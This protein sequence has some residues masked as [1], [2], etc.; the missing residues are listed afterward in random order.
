LLDHVLKELGKPTKMDAITGHPMGGLLGVL[1]KGFSYAQV[2]RPTAKFGP[3]MAFPPANPQLT[4][5]VEQADAVKLRVL[6]QV[7]FD[8][9]TTETID[10]V[11]TANGLPVVTLE[12]KTD[13]TQTVNDAITQ[14]KVD[15]VPGPTRALLAPGR[16]LVHFG[17]SNDRVFMTT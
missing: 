11:L 7:R 5:V 8:T 6:R 3:L 13:N 15:R 14:Y 17:V 2:G 1:R 10:V 4:S 9:K 16:A 12:L